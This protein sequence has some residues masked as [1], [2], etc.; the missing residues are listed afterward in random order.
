MNWSNEKSR[1]LFVRIHPSNAVAGQ[2]IKDRGVKAIA[3]CI[4]VS[5]LQY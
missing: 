5:N 2:R 1:L 3:E 4:N